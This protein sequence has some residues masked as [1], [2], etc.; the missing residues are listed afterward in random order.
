MPRPTPKFAALMRYAAIL[1]DGEVNACIRDYRHTPRFEYS[2]EAVA[3]YG[4]VS[5]VVLRAAQLRT[6][7]R[8]RAMLSDTAPRDWSN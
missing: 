7:Y 1:S 6:N 5:A 2:S 8:L 3:H 4:G